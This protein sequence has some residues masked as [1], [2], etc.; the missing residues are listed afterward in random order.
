Y[1]T[2][3]ETRTNL[4]VSPMY[5]IQPEISTRLR[6]LTIRLKDTLEPNTTY[7]FNFGSAIRDFNEGNILRDFDY[8]FSTGPAL[9]SLSLGGIVTLAETGGTD[10]TLL[11]ELYRNLQDSAVVTQ[12]PRYITHPDAEGRFRFRNLPAGTFAVYVL[13][14]KNNRRYLAKNQLFGFLDS[15]VTT[16]RNNTPLQL[17]AYRE[18]PAATNGASPSGAPRS[19]PQ[20]ATDRRLKYS[21]TPGT[22]DLQSDFRITFDN[23]VKTFDSSKVRL[24]RDS[25]T[26]VPASLRLDS[27]RH[28][29]SLRTAW[30]EGASYQLILEKDFATDTTGRSQLRNDTI[31]FSAKRSTDYGK[32]LLRFRRAIPSSNPVLQF[33][34]GDKVV[35]SAPVGSGTFSRDLFP[36]G[37]YDLRLLFDRNGNGV[38]DAGRFFGGKRQPEIVLP[39]ERKLTVK[40]DLDNEIEIE[41]PQP[42]GR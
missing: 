30:T 16:G 12:G 32:L 27:T 26:A 15:S 17:Y 8:T 10:T 1:I 7:T 24:Y 20:A 40:P 39:V 38:W 11:V 22:Q 41:L 25:T 14:D 21:T 18:T 23:K 4:T 3:Q 35:F 2:L 42:P 31:L 34:Q 13:E 33:V 28:V 5:E 6:T 29:L 9:D 37:D 19:T 36:P